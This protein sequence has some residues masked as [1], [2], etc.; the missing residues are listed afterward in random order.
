MQKKRSKNSPL[1]KVL[2][3]SRWLHIYCSTALF[4]LLI[5]FCITG[6]WLNHRWYDQDNY[7]QQYAEH[8]ITDELHLAWG[9]PVQEHWAPDTTAITRYLGDGYGLK[10]PASMDIDQDLNE[11]VIEYKVPA[12]FASVMIIGEERLIIIE[13]ETGSAVG[14]LN[15]LHKGRN[16]GSVWSWLIDLCAALM[17]LFAITGMIILFQ[18]KK[19]RRE[20][21]ISALAGIL[22][23]L[24]LYFLFVP[25]IGH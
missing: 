23:P 10:G 12:G 2:K 1:N 17:M 14:I 13:T 15:D 8:E 18:G 9:L 7:Q 22:T 5:F 4:A 16:S 11:L 24:I 25:S 21:M 3:A 19:Y 20:G 6:I